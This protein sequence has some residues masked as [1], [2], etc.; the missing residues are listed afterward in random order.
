MRDIRVKE[1][2]FDLSN[3]TDR[4]LL[5]VVEENTDDFGD[6]VIRLLYNWAFG[7]PKS[8]DENRQDPQEDIRNSGLPFG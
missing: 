7:N 4:K 3:P 2:S 1:I 8:M 5:A 6:L